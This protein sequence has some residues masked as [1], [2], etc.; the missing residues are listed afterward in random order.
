MTMRLNLQ[1]ILKHQMVNA[2]PSDDNLN[3]AM[4]TPQER[5]TL[6]LGAGASP[7]DQYFTKKLNIE[8]RVNSMMANIHHHMKSKCRWRDR[9]QIC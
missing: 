8:N 7:A 9:N 4:P 6:R 3:L 5:A 2:V 1:N